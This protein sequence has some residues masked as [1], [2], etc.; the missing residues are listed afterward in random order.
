MVTGLLYKSAGRI[1][2]SAAMARTC[3][4]HVGSGRQRLR[5]TLQ[6]LRAL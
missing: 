5:S 4:K 6:V 1:P 2:I 3:N